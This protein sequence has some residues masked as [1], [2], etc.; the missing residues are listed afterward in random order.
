MSEPEA[1]KE[2]SGHCLRLKQDTYTL[3]AAIEK[4]P[5]GWQRTKMLTAWQK[6]YEALQEVTASLN[7]K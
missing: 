2:I 7:W 4:F 1:R 5:A 3:K 6:S